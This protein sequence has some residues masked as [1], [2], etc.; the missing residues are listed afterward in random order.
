MSGTGKVGVGIG[1]AR[2]GIR[3]L[4]GVGVPAG[5]RRVKQDLEDDRIGVEGRSVGGVREH[6]CEMPG[7]APRLNGLGKAPWAWPLLNTWVPQC[8]VPGSRKRLR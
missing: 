2:A 6:W 4:V 8:V 7:H 3:G 5:Q 1:D